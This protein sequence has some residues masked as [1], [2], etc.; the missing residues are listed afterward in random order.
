MEMPKLIKSEI[1]GINKKCS[2]VNKGKSTRTKFNT[3]LKTP[4]RND[5]IRDKNNVANT[6][7]PHDRM[8]NSPR[9]KSLLVRAQNG[10]VMF[11]LKE[12]IAGIIKMRMGKLSNGKI[13]IVN[14]TPAERDPMIEITS[15]GKVSLTM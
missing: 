13:K 4:M 10:L 11:P 14:I 12:R 15:D 8:L 6:F 3:K 1:I 9:I 7:S 5:D 2:N